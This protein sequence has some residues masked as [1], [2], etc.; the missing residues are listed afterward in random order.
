MPTTIH[1][2]SST[3]ASI[4]HYPP[5]SAAYTRPDIPLSDANPADE[6]LAST[7]G[8]EF[9][10][11][12]FSASA[13]PR[14]LPKLFVEGT[15]HCGLEYR[16]EVF[17]TWG[18]AMATPE[19]I[20]TLKHNGMH[21]AVGCGMHIHIG[22]EGLPDPALF[23]LCVRL[24]MP[25]FKALVP[26]HR[27]TWEFCAPQSSQRQAH[28]AWI[29][30]NYFAQWL[31][32][33]GR[34]N[35]SVIKEI[36]P[37]PPVQLDLQ[38]F[39]KQMDTAYWT[40]PFARLSDKKAHSLLN[41]V[42]YRKF[43]FGTDHAPVLG[44]GGCDGPCMK[45]NSEHKTAEIRLFDSTFNEAKSVAYL[46][47]VNEFVKA[48]KKDS[49][50]LLTQLVKNQRAYCLDANRAYEPEY[51]DSHLASSIFSFLSKEVTPLGSPFRE[52]NPNQGYLYHPSTQ[53]EIR[54]HL[55][56]ASP[57]LR[58]WIAVHTLLC[59]QG[60]PINLDDAYLYPNVS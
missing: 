38:R 10:C 11:N 19:L 25:V 37:Q 56:K 39:K 41:D 3:E 59:A 52:S 16:S 26:A 40:P 17:K 23:H 8:V 46:F 29:T 30:K 15:D 43:S 36:L 45:F 49:S 9:E 32:D 5:Q 35:K 27:W 31:V 33:E 13:K 34:L 54:N 24:A 20:A 12:P 55:A 51:Q 42:I 58:A 6:Q 7:L 48:Y 44:D 50:A 22:L 57:K 21:N 28:L 4:H 60:H 18:D 14:K 2:T 47:F 1:L 53:R